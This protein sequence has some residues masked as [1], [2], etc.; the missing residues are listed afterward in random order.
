[1]QYEIHTLHRVNINIGSRLSY[2]HSSI[3]RIHS[4]TLPIAFSCVRCRSNSYICNYSTCIRRDNR[5]QKYMVQTF[6][7]KDVWTITKHRST[8]A[9][10]PTCKDKFTYTFK[11]TDSCVYSIPEQDSVNKLTG[12]ADGSL[13]H[14]RNSFR[15]GWSYDPTNNNI[16]LYA[17]M[18]RN[19]IRAID[20]LYSIP[21]N[22]THSITVTSTPTSYI[23]R[24]ENRITSYERPPHKKNNYKHHLYP[25][26]GGKY[27]TPQPLIIYLSHSS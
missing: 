11:F 13:N 14:H 3:Q 20:Y 21:L 24:S 8:I 9:Y 15:I 2:K 26:F 10:K 23:V 17:Y 6:D 19:G 12:F 27:P 25:Y 16:K 1:M 7:Q 5:Q 22:Q 4:R 18:Y